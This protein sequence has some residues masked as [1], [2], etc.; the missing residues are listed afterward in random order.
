MLDYKLMC[1][2]Q[3]AVRKGDRI[4]QRGF[5]AGFECGAAFWRALRDVKDAKHK[6]WEPY[7]CSR[8]MTFES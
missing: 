4:L 2:V 3:N 7:V 5:G 6:A 1:C 8:V